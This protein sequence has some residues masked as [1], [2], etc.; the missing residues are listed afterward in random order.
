MRYTEN[1]LKDSKSCGCCLG[2]I[3]Q[4]AKNEFYVLRA[5]VL[6]ND[7]TRYLGPKA[8]A[9]ARAT[10]EERGFLADGAVTDAGREALE[11]HRVKHAIFQAAG[12]CRRFSPISYDIPKGL[13]EVHGERL[14]ERQIRQLHEVGITDITIVVGHLAESFDYLVDKYAVKLLFN[15][16]YAQYNTLATIYHARDLLDNAYILYSDHYY[17][18]NL[19]NTYEY[20]SFYPTR[21]DNPTTEWT[22]VYD[23]D[24][25][26]ID[27]VKS[28]CG[29][30]YLHGFAYITKETAD[31]MMPYLEDAYNDKAL[32]NN[33]WEHVMWLGRGHIHIDCDI[34]P[35]GTVN[36][37]DTVDQLLA[38]D[39]SFIEKVDSPSLDIICNA[40]GCKRSDIHDF[41]PLTAGLT[42]VSC[43]FAVGDDEFVYRH[44]VGYANPD[45]HRDDEARIEEVARE[46]GIDRTF[47]CMDPEVGWKISRYVPN[48]HSMDPAN[49]EDALRGAKTLGGLHE[50]T[51]GMT[52]EHRF[53][54]WQQCLTFE[55]NTLSR[56]PVPDE[57]FPEYR[58]KMGR[59]GE[60][61]ASDSYPDEF[62]HN[63]AWYSNML[64][65]EDNSFDFIDWEN[66]CMADPLSDIAYFVEVLYIV[67]PPTDFETPRVLLEAYLGREATPE[68]WR[69]F[70]GLMTI[71]CWK[72]IMWAYDFKTG[73]PAAT[74]WP[75]DTWIEASYPFIDSFAPKVLELYGE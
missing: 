1:K 55:A 58:A 34:W 2:V 19:F 26:S 36:E 4:L 62:S 68:E 6:G 72:V 40:L 39:P 48:A 11:P 3:M 54:R 51:A 50:A 10:L 60:L 27:M 20:H 41:F 37:F 33:F 45:V 67:V 5:L 56:G 32:R 61:V 49:M 46:L 16:E 66:A 44:P 17:H 15:P 65:G 57:R 70:L 8:E 9:W 64:I 52:S 14:V 74:D 75:I 35:H 63:D 53:D 29:G 25:N 18:E 69:H 73:N 31:E 23:E 30:E 24:R 12:L 43:H 59:I 22:Q 21:F 28:D 71:T 7:V 38:F 47:V 42:N 13:L